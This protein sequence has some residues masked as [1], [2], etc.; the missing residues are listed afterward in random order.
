MEYD[1]HIYAQETSL[2]RILHRTRAKVPT[3]CQSME[4]RSQSSRR[5]DCQRVTLIETLQD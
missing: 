2:C 5:Y 1:F 4:H 3:M